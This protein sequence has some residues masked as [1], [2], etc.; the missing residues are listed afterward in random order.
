L[1]PELNLEGSLGSVGVFASVP[2]VMA[3]VLPLILLFR[4]GGD[5][6]QW[7]SDDQLPMAWPVIGVMLLLLA[8]AGRGP[9]FLAVVAFAIGIVLLWMETIPRPGESHGGSSTGSLMLTFASVIGF[10][11]V[12][13]ESG[14]RWLML[15]LCMVIAACMLA[16]T[17]IRLGSRCAT[18][19][20]GWACCLGPILLL[21]LVGQNGLLA[22]IIGYSSE[23]IAFVGYRQLVGLEVLVLPGLLILALSGFITGWVRWSTIRGRLVAVLLAAGAAGL[24]VGLLMP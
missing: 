15:I 18:M 13:N 17:A 9:E 20:A 8:V 1:R 19:A 12:A 22:S 16:S 3:I 11:I 2:L 10:S 4:L 6:R 24:S 23:D 21:G 7:H 5:G 14:S